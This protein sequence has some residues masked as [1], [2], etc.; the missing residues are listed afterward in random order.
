MRRVTW[1]L[2]A[3]MAL[4]STAQ[5]ADAKWFRADTESFIIYSESNEESLRDFAQTLQ[6]FDLTLRSV[7]NV[8]VQ[9]EENRLPIYL[10]AK[11]D[12][13][14]RLASGSRGSSIAGFYSPHSEGSFAVSNRES[15]GGVTRHSTSAAQ[16]TLFHEYTHHFM[17]RYLTSA[18]PAWFVEGFAEYYSTTDFN[19]E[20]KAEIGKPAYRRAYGLL[21]LPKIPAATLVSQT[22]GNMRNSGQADV[23]Y[24]RAW[25]LTHMLYHDPARVKQLAPYIRAINT[26]SDPQKAA[27]DSF[28]DLALLDK[29]LN[30]YVNNRLT[31]RLTRDPIPVP[32][33]IRITP[34]SAAES[35]V[36]PLRLERL[37]A[38]DDIV[39]TTKV[40]D[41]LRKL[42]ATYPADAGVWFELAAAEWSLGDKRN[43]AA[44]RTS[45]DKSLAIK[46]D[47]VRA[48]VL[49]GQLLIHELQEKDDDSA[50]N[51]RAARRPI[52]LANRTDPNDPTPLL[53]YY[54]SFLEQ[55]ERPSAMTIKALERAFVLAPENIETRVAYAVSLA[56]QGQFEPAIQLAKTVAFDPHQNGGG[57][58]LL[59][60]LEAMR[61][62]RSGAP[63][64]DDIS[65]DVAAPAAAQ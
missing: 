36:I 20:G 57:D 6:R 64:T 48:N 35:A 37:S 45:L 39:R 4:F 15:Y 28:G 24:G 8:P 65:K 42:S 49:L 60:Q 33:D 18:F 47:H 52:Q 59:A 38:H 26:G 23:Y 16:Q 51:W 2:M 29:D 31:Y 1:G 46:A 12:D 13:A 3:G 25:L 56:N 62:G 7:I 40:R 19:N 14:G 54:N 44:V 41:E 32:A 53:A 5:T 21:A 43:L 30:R 61:D 58:A 50:E 27:T 63:A 17:K 11:A 10:V 34:L 22:P 55:G 9:G